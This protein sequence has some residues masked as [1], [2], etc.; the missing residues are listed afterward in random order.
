MELYDTNPNYMTPNLKMFFSLGVLTIT[1]SLVSMTPKTVQSPKVKYR[2][3]HNGHYL[4]LSKQ[5]YDAHVRD[6]AKETKF[7]CTPAG[8]CGDE[9]VPPPK[10]E[11]SGCQRS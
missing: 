1:I 6:H 10:E 8:M 3:L 5:G 2:V 4:C 9:I 11:C 7:A